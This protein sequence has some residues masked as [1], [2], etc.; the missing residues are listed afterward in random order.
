MRRAL[1]LLVA[2]AFLACP[3]GRAAPAG[4]KLDTGE[5]EGARFTI[6]RPAQWNRFLL[7]VAH[8]YREENAPLVADLNPAHLAYRTLLDEG[9]MV[10]KTSYRR[11]G[12]VIEDAIADLD[13]LRAHI[14]AAYGEPQRV[15]LEGDSM[16]GAIVTLMAE[17]PAGRYHG[18]VAVDAALQV[19]ERG[20]AVAFNLE[21]QIPLVFLVNRSEL[22]ASRQYVT[23]P[24]ER[25]VRPVLLQVARDGHVNVSQRERLAA[26]RA[27]AALVDRQPVALPSV[28]G[29]PAFFDATQPPAPGPSQ[30]R[31]RNEGGFE[32]R[33]TEVTGVFGNLVLTAQPDDLA[34]ADIATGTWFELIA[35]GQAYRVFFGRDFADVRRGQWIAFANADGFLILGRNHDNAAATAGLR[36]G[37]MVI[38][39]RLPAD[40]GGDAAEPP[41]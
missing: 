20:S 2:L 14:A 16:G 8:G 23:A 17:R 15:V 12:L 13:N 40:A 3:A 21:P 30:V 11:N 41:P 18:A 34:R 4:I 24:L 39:H 36:D 25:P 28:D 9:W 35:P 27:V 7:L 31:L 32:A 29:A 19:R 10:A 22:A 26:I 37:D 5:I 38:I 6:A 1:P 33:V